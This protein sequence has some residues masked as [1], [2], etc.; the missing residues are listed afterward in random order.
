GSTFPELMMGPA[1]QRVPQISYFCGGLMRL[2][3]TPVGLWSDSGLLPAQLPALLDRRRPPL[4]DVGGQIDQMH[5]ALR[6]L[7]RFNA[8][9]RE[10]DVAA[11][12]LAQ[13]FLDR[14]MGKEVATDLIKR[15]HG[16][17]VVLR[18]QQKQGRGGMCLL[19]RH[20]RSVPRK[21][22]CRLP[23]RR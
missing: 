16:H 18:H 21:M 5:A 4:V 12:R 15:Y 8:N 23:D 7:T 17:A 1:E 11:Q 2:R 3:G 14:E 10:G 13:Q 6:L 22:Q 9:G 19:V 20:C